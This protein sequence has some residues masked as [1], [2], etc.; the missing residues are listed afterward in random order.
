MPRNLR[1]LKE[2]ETLKEE[3]R[4]KAAEDL[5]NQ[6]MAAFDEAYELDDEHRAIIASDIK[7]MSEE[8]FE[9]YN[10]KMEV[11]LSRQKYGGNE[12]DIPDA[13]RKKEGHHGKG[14]KT[15]ETAKEEG[16]MDFKKDM[17]ATEEEVV[18]S[19]DEQDA[20]NILDSAIE[21]AEVDKTQLPSTTEASDGT[22]AEKYEK[23]F[24]LDNFEI[25]Y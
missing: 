7:D 4:I 24:N 14:P 10:K 3:Q 15:K 18:A 2:L 20:E 17:K 21:N 22:L 12:G 23:A 6:R 11:L 5:F 19:T 1:L 9:S 13:D 16:E 25:D 8:D